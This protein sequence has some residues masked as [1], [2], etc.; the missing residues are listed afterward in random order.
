MYQI[1]TKNL[2]ARSLNWLH[3]KKRESWLGT[4]R[5]SS[6]TL[7]IWQTGARPQLLTPRSDHHWNQVALT[8]LISMAGLA[9][10]CK[11]FTK[12]WIIWSATDTI[13]R[14]PALF[15]QTAIHCDAPCYQIIK[16]CVWSRNLRFH[17]NEF[18]NTYLFCK[19]VYN[20]Q[21]CICLM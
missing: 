11:I 1:L 9:S 20:T 8:C 3:P 19:T 7:H 14:Y 21:P 12:E 17:C 2:R 18:S 10:S 5:F 16:F 15:S 6:K 4:S 13:T